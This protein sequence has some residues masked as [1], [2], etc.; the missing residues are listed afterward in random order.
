MKQK[1]KSGRK[2]RIFN[3]FFSFATLLIT[4]TFSAFSFST[5]ASATTYSTTT[6]S[7]ANSF[8]F[9]DF[10]ADYYLTREDDGT[11]RMIV[12]EELTAVFP[13]SNQ[14]HGITRVIPF[15]NN[16]GK[17]LTMDTGDTI[18]MDVER[19][20]VEEPVSKVE[21]GDGY[22]TVYIGDSDS[23][24]HG[25]QTYTLTYEFTNL[26]LDF[27]TW[28]EL[29][30]DANG[31]DWQQR[32]NNVTAR[33][34]L[35]EDVYD[36]FTGETS[37]Y[38][39]RYGE[40]GNSRCET[41]PLIDGVE[42]TA[43]KLSARETLT[44]DLKF[45]ANTFALPPQKFDYRLVAVCG[46][47]V[48]A[49]GAM[50]AL[51][52]ACWRSVAQKRAFYDGLFVKPEYTPPQDLTVA[53]MAENYFG[54]GA[55]GDARVATLLELAVNHKIEMIKG[56]RDA[57]FG[58]KKTEWTIKVK[59]DTLNKEQATVLKILAGS[60]TPL[61]VGQEIKIKTHTANSEL[62]SLSA[63]FPTAVRNAL[64][65][66][67]LFVDTDTAKATKP[68][69][70]DLPNLLLTCTI[71]WTILGMM[72]A[73]FMFTDVPTYVNMIGGQGLFGEDSSFGILHLVNILILAGICIAGY[74]VSGKCSHFHTRTEKG[75]EYVKYMDGL[76]MYI[77]MAEA[78]RLKMLQSVKGADTSH[79]GVVKIYE[80]LLPY[81][82]IFKLEKSWLDEM[83][84]YYEFDDVSAPVWYVGIGA[85]SARDFSSA[86]M[87]ASSSASSTITYSTTSNSS[88]G[89]SGG[90][91]GGFS[92]GGG[93]GGGGGGW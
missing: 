4:L 13:S 17:N 77:Q 48:V 12:V 92:G 30:W 53:E 54:K 3:R 8:Y 83:S 57:A 85:F 35:D 43:S 67:G 60:K 22:Y 65:K 88:S 70:R 25:E 50:V 45:D 14:N 63:E 91:G 80:K 26:I 93:G 46:I 73:V 58:K 15:T 38:V 47:L 34:H 11:S 6:Y 29:Y 28:Q 71:I 79:T 75:L 44:F 52:I 37:C 32:F 51:M 84:H 49:G 86:M 5:P 61:R 72:V 69:K 82:A 87:A 19:N 59:T 89:F 76:R 68:K 39:G 16:D 62:T 1:I 23:Y 7:N 90:G 55:S 21:I 18:Y 31:N 9:K 78:D 24:V 36:K 42:F 33:V 20:G 27:D 81:A 10:T 40:N 74:M 64:K 41:S 66:K 56:E 2:P